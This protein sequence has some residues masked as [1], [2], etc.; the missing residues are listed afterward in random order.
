[1]KKADNILT[2][3]CDAKGCGWSAKEVADDVSKWHRAKCPKCGHAPVVSDDD[4]AVLAV[5]LGLRDLGLA[6]IGK[7]GKL[8][9]PH[10]EVKFNTRNL[11]SEPDAAGEG[12][13][14]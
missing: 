9:K 12:K 8:D 3:Q 4:L 5:M 14:E 7:G 2:V 13:P 10:V 11:R 1:M 6:T